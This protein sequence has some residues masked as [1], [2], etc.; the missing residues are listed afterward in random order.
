MT[1]Q[2]A[3]SATSNSVF[4][5]VRAVRGRPEPVANRHET[6]ELVLRPVFAISEGDIPAQV[7]VEPSIELL[8][9]AED[10]WERVLQPV[11]SLRA[12]PQ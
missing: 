7:E 2:K 5:H 11:N 9:S 10:Y 1:L 8:D 4:S 12:S 6:V 3:L